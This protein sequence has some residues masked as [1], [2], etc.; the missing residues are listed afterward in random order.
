MNSQQKTVAILGNG[1]VGIAVAKGFAELGYRVIFGTRDVGSSKTRDA[2]AVVTGATATSYAAAAHAADIAFIAVPYAALQDVL[3]LA[4]AENLAG[5]LV[6]DATNPVDFSTGAPQLAI[7]F[8]DSAGE[9]VQRALPNAKVVKAF[10][11]IAAHR[12]VHPQFTDGTPDMIIAGNDAAAKVTVTALLEQF[13]WRKA[14]DLGDITASRL[15]ESL[16]MVWISYAF[17]NN[18]WTHGFSV[19]G[20]G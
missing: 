12:M 1:A 15:L 4:G 10:N 13:G 2:V 14:I 19:L 5:K 7:G 9:I 3:A 8:T 17:K 11:I 18:H 6:I 20:R 16:A